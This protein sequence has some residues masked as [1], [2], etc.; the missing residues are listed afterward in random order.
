MPGDDVPV[1]HHRHSCHPSG[2][3][4]VVAVTVTSA[5]IGGA[6]FVTVTNAGRALSSI[7]N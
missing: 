1:L 3:E 6:A 5:A 7:L 4:A 2:G